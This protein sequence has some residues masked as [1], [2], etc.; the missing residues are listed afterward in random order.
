MARQFGAEQ[1]R[2][3]ITAE[4]SGLENRRLAAFASPNR[5]LYETF[6][7][8]QNTYRTTL[9][10]QADQIDDTLPELVDRIVRRLYELFDFFTPPPTMIAE[11]LSQMRRRRS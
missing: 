10:A 8:R 3:I 11:E 2:V 4:W 7:A 5:Q 6:A 1:A 9:E